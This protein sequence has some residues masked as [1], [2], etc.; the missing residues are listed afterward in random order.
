MRRYIGLSLILIGFLTFVVW[1]ISQ[2]IQPILPPQI[3]NSL[4]LFFVALVSSVG[5]IAAFKDTVEFIRF[6]FVDNEGTSKSER[7]FT[8]ANANSLLIYPYDNPPYNSVELHYVGKE[9][10]KDVQVWKIFRDKGGLE[11]RVEIQQFFP[12]ND[13]KMIWH[14][15]PVNVLRENDIVRFHLITKDDTLDGKSTVEVR[16]VGAQSGSE[17]KIK[18]MIEL[19]R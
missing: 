15:V 6:F 5:F 1:A 10:A 11:K 19:R 18:K 13:L 3:N 9:Q 12:H 16:F 2:F 4:A 17:I 8:P 14:H 7:A